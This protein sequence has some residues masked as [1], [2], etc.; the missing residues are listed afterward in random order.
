M[1][2]LLSSPLYT[3]N[4]NIAIGEESFNASKNNEMEKQ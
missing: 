2:A 4:S 3:V 1:F